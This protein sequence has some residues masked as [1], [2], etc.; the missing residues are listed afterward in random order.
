MGSAFIGKAKVRV[1]LYSAGTTFENR[2]FR[3]LENVS[4]FQ[5]SFS[6]E[7]KKL[8][9]YASAA[10]G[11]DASIKRI[12]DVTG[13]MDLRHFTADNLAL[14][15]WGTTAALSA[16]A[17]VGE[18][19]YKIVPLAFVPDQAPD[20]YQRRASREEGR[21]G[22]QHERLHGICRRYHHCLIDQHRWRGQRRCDHD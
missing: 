9:D 5:F 6:E 11:V 17:I 12:T 16:V 2:P 1:A 10:G 19:G 13:S 22:R 15:L 21:H 4:A 20:Q 7:E 3:Y 8:L 14:A 18:A